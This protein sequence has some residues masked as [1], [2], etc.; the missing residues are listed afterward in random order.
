MWLGVQVNLFESADGRKEQ[1]MADY[2]FGVLGKAAS[3]THLQRTRPHGQKRSAFFKL[4]SLALST[5]C[6]RF[7]TVS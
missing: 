7:L 6:A 5:R 1:A 4:F 3:H 2:I